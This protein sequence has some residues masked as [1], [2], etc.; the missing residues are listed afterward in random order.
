MAAAE[1][2]KSRRV[3][4]YATHTGTRDIT[5]RMDDMLPRHGFRVAV[6]KADAVAPER[7][8][9]WVADKVKQGIDVMICH[10]K[11]V[12]TGLD[13]IDFPTLIWY[14]T[15][16]SVFQSTQ[17]S[18]VLM[19]SRFGVRPALNR[20]QQAAAVTDLPSLVHR[21]KGLLN[22]LRV[23]AF[24]GGLSGH[25]SQT[26]PSPSPSRALG[27]IAFGNPLPPPTLPCTLDSPASTASSHDPY[28]GVFSS[29][30]NS[31]TKVGVAVASPGAVRFDVSVLAIPFDLSALTSIG[32]SQV[33]SI[34]MTV[35]IRDF[36]YW[37]SSDSKGSPN[38]M[39]ASSSGTARPVNR[40][41]PAGRRHLRARIQ[42]CLSGPLS[43][44]SASRP[45]LS[46]HW[47][48][49]Y[50]PAPTSNGSG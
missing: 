38:E 3:L 50:L 36:P 32:S 14:E 22:A 11:L 12:Q 42:D 25:R 10:P 27:T 28:T 18:K 37:Q 1:R 15:E 4:V 19:G 43:S 2:M 48:L 24:S 6:M 35:S 29:G 23:Q 26:T 17:K 20:W 47:P 13:L 33:S 40:A 44:R 9:A 8:E 21:R 49:G 7:R 45:N 41:A 30:S 5:E 39:G 34:S 46:I 16:F 31:G